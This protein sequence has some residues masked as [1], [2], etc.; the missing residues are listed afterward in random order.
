MRGADLRD[1]DLKNS[2]LDNIDL[3]QSNLRG[4][5]LYVSERKYSKKDYIFPELSQST[6]F[7]N[8]YPS[9]NEIESYKS[10][11]P[12]YNYELSFYN[13]EIE[14]YKKAKEKLSS[15]AVL[16]QTILP[17]GEL[18]EPNCKP[19]PQNGI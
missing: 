4:A 14:L 15:N 2:R 8:S 9:K 5:K 7:Y 16:C 11:S 12:F 13:D 19:K 1:A 10:Y 6:S 3:T 18:A 17:S